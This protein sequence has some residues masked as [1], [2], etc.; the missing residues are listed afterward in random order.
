MKRLIFLI[1]MLLLSN[2]I[3]SQTNDSLPKKRASFDFDH[4]QKPDVLNTAKVVEDSYYSVYKKGKKTV[5]TLLS[6]SIKTMNA[7]GNILMTEDYLITDTANIKITYLYDEKGSCTKKEVATYDKTDRHITSITTI[8][9]K[10][11]IGM[12]EKTVCMYNKEGLCTS[13]IQYVYIE[14]EKRWKEMANSNGEGVSPLKIASEKTYYRTNMSNVVEEEHYHFND[15]LITT[16]V[17]YQKTP[18]DTCVLFRKDNVETSRRFAL[19]SAGENKFHYTE[20]TEY[21]LPIKSGKKV[22]NYQLVSNKI[23]YRNAGSLTTVFKENS[24]E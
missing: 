8:F 11:W 15:A 10:E 22:K 21:L 7:S 18:N 17:Y 12:T 1:S 4:I 20:I 16:M 6:S 2:A 19:R 24:M 3:L 5:Q 13:M 14:D 23:T 9:L